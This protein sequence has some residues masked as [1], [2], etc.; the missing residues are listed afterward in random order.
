MDG[1]QT[2][3][4]A[5]V[6]YLPPSAMEATLRAE[7]DV[8]I[9]T[10]KKY[11]R[12]VSIAL[13]KS[14]QWATMTPAIAESCTYA[15]PRGKNDD[16]T[17]KIVTGPSIR[18]AE[19]IASCWGNIRFGSRMIDD[20]GKMITV[21][22]FAADL[23]ANTAYSFELKAKVT[24]RNGRRYSDD[25]IVMASNAAGSKALRNAV[26]K[27]VPKAFVQEIQAEAKRVAIGDQ[28]TFAAR[29]KSAVDYFKTQGVEK[30]RVLAL[31]GKADVNDLDGND[32]V[33]LASVINA[34]KDGETTIAEAFP[35]AKQS[36]ADQLA[37]KLPLPDGELF[38]GKGQG[39][40]PR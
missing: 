14:K 30:D 25:M 15:I 28:K 13:N 39:A 29:R 8:Q 20:D 3:E 23:E 4:A 5:E 22:G 17:P 21:Q 16:G 24:D 40:P 2:G 19:I 37:A 34:V 35:D 31:C 18:L 11:P 36:K 26:F 9:A 1:M 10:A 12:S 6:K 27:V 7:I 38:D 33:M 32:L